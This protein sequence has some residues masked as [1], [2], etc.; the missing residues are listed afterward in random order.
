MHSFSP[1]VTPLWFFASEVYWPDAALRE[2]TISKIETEMRRLLSGISECHARIVSDEATFQRAMAELDDV[3]GLA[4]FVALSGGVQPWMLKLGERYEQV[5]VVNA[6]LPEGV[7]SSVAN[8]L[9][10]R[11]AHPASTDFYAHRRRSGRGVHWIFDE[12][13]VRRVG[14]GW[15][16]ASAV[17]GATLLRVGP[18]EPWVINSER[19][20]AVFADRL[21]ARV[22]E[23]ELEA[24]YAA[25]QRVDDTAAEALADDWVSGCELEDGVTRSDV[26]KACRV[27]AAMRSMLQEHDAVG[28]SIACFKMI[29]DLDTTSCLSVSLLNDDPA[30]LGAC[31]GDLDAAVTMLLLKGVGADFVWIANPI[32]HRDT[33]DLVHCTAPR[34]ACRT[35]LSYSLRRHH[36]SGRGVAPRV[37]LPVLQRVTLARIG[38]GLR[39]LGVYGGIA[40]PAPALAAC[41]TQIRVK[42]DQ[43]D[44]LISTL[45]GTH[46][47]MSYGEHGGTLRTAAEMLGLEAVG[48]QQ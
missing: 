10:H 3:A 47:V 17:R 26:V 39:R 7:A 2:S 31:E 32:I 37:M 33:V 15:R 19:D 48:D 27:T 30:L 21:G 34:C 23:L 28:L 5:A 41:H 29:G 36:E 13:D 12:D 42:L 9:L 45:M 44:R 4:W 43:P 14:S 18:T 16:G 46:V 20:P 38:D 6:Y 1:A 40:E 11:N 22:V 25:T 24:L 35:Q 8:D